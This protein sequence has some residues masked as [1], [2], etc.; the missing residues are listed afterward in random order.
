MS[1][2]YTT[3]ATFFLE[4]I[5]RSGPSTIASSAAPGKE[6]D[7]R[8]GTRANQLPGGTRAGHQCQPA[9]KTGEWI[10]A[11]HSLRGSSGRPSRG[12]CQSLVGGWVQQQQQQQQ[13][14]IG[15]Y[16]PART[17]LGVGACRRRLSTDDNDDCYSVLGCREGLVTRAIGKYDVR[18]AGREEQAPD[19]SHGRVSSTGHDRC[20]S[21]DDGWPPS[22]PRWSKAT[23]ASSWASTRE[24]A[25]FLR[26]SWLAG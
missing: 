21:V 5:I 12:A 4:A 25:S 14:Q 7:S 20:R 6:D 11:P 13:Q 22:T 15:A 1:C 2:T 19:A 3:A 24:R 8:V 16:V 18:Q 26:A 17:L 9:L 23:H 10:R